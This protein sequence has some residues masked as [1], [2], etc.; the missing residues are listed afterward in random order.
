MKKAI[1][2]YISGS[3]QSLFFRQ[4]IKQ[5]ADE[6]NVKGF[7][8]MREDGRVEVF[9]EGDSEDVDAVAS[10]CKRGPQH[11]NIRNIEEK[12]EKPQYFKEFKILRF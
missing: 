9:L 5:H 8:R 6:H 1:R 7:L 11:A 3:I 10:I 2:M 4:F 12:E